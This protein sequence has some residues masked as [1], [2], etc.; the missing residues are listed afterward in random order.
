MSD[1]V[2]SHGERAVALM[3]ADGM[4]A[5][6]IAEERDMTPKTVEQSI[7]RIREK[8]DRALATLAESPFTREAMDPETANW[9]GEL[10]ED[11]ES[12]QR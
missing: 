4:T 1:S 6:E 11:V 2:L 12:D 8:T 10:L 3:I 5:E 9:L 7:D